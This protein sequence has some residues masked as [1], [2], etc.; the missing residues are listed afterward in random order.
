MG[1]GISLGG[2]YQANRASWAVGENNGSLLPN[3][4]RLDGAVSYQR[5]D[6]RIALNVYNLLNDYLYSGSTYPGYYYW[7]TEPGTNFRMNVAYQF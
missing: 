1:L 5:D 3:Y 6:F 7:Q 2:Q 4:F